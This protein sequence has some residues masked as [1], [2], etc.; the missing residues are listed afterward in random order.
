MSG[1]LRNEYRV[2]TD[3]EL[4]QRVEMLANNYRS[5][6]NILA[7]PERSPRADFAAV[8]KSA[9]EHHAFLAGRLHPAAVGA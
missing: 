7:N 5:A 1:W 8:E 4:D 3:E 6:Q 2:D 9:D